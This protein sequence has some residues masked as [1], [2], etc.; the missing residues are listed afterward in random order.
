[1]RHGSQVLQVFNAQPVH[2]ATTRT[3]SVR[4][5]A[6]MVI[7]GYAIGAVGLGG[8]VPLV[9][10][11]EADDGLSPVGAVAEEAEVGQGLF[12][13]AE[14]ALALGELV[15]EGHEEVAVALALVLRQGEDAGNVVAL[16]GFLLLA[17]IADQVVPPLVARGHAVEEEGV[18][19]V[20]E[21]LVIEEELREQ[22][23]VAAPGP[24][25][26]AVDLEEGDR[27]VA[28]DFVAGRV[29]EG[30]L[31]AVTGEG[32]EGVVVAEAEL[33]DV[34]QVRFGEGSWVRREVPG[35]HLGVTHLDPSDVANP[36]DFGLVLCH[37]SA[38]A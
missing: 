32:L 13:G 23:E 8:V 4:D 17:E 21:G 10:N 38:R 28:V 12:W 25:A 19:V 35:F 3:A 31:G 29:D 24:L 22:A 1:M 15:G 26:A 2:P 30:A 36:G 14:L 27:A 7:V 18:D 6:A 9:L 20:V 37:R 16:G 33:A 34:D 5:A 11:D